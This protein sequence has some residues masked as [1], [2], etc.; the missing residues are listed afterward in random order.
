MVLA[1][2]L[3]SLLCLLPSSR[4][5]LHY[6]LLLE[7]KQPA[8]SRG[9]FESTAQKVPSNNTDTDPFQTLTLQGAGLINMSD[10]VYNITII[11]S[12]TE[13]ILHDTAHFKSVSHIRYLPC[14]TKS[15]HP[16]SQYF[17]VQN[18]ESEVE[19]CTIR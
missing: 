8:R 11:L 13:L 4:V 10:A 6:S 7:E 2:S 12:P 18:N 5:L 14:F 15:R 1:F 3:G 17:T 16:C 9:L 19:T